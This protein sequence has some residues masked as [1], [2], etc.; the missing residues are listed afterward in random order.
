MAIN[1]KNLGLEDSEARV[2][3]ALLELGPSTVSEITKKAGISRTLGYDV[4]ERLAVQGLVDRV[5]GAKSKIKYAANHPRSLLQFTLNRKNQWERRAKEVAGLLPE[6]VSLYKIAEKPVVRFQAGIGGIKT[7]YNETLESNSEVLALLD[8]EGWDI[9]ELRAWAKTYNA[10]RSRRRIHE[11]VLMMDTPPGREWMKF[12]RGSFK[13]TE[14]RWIKPDQ[15]PGLRAF[16]GEVN[17][18]DNK[19][20]LALLQPPNRMGVCVESLALANLMKALF[21]FAWAEGAPIKVH[22]RRH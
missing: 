5:S 8:I 9:P 22:K 11:R 20:L 15:V 10:E 18:F 14:Y 16:G 4:L 19:V 17:I 13:Y 1:L 6:L 3:E 2:Y 21:E 7:I 12:Y